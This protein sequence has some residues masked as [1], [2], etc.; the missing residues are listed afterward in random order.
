MNL[1]KRLTY[2]GGGLMMGIFFLFFFLNGKKA[3]CD[4]LPNDRV[5]KNIR[6]KKLYYSEEAQNEMLSLKIDSTD[7]KKI[8]NFGDVDF[9][10][11]NTKSKP[12]RKYVITGTSNEEKE[13]ELTIKNCAEDA[14]IETVI[15]K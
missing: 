2:F 7:I 8:L 13:I 14:R 10:R 12:C 3:S 11:S 9:D 4:Y 6:T 15:S 1:F 5:L